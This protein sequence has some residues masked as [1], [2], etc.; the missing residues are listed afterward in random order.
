MWVPDDKDVW[1]MEAVLSE[2]ADGNS[3]TV[4]AKDGKREVEVRR[5]ME[6]AQN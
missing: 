6:A 4:R 1:R 5:N 2:S 3:Y